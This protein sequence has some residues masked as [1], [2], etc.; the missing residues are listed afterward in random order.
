MDALRAADFQGPLESVLG[1]GQMVAGVAMLGGSVLG[2]V[3][4]QVTNLGVPFLMRV[5][6]LL[7]R[8]IVAARMMH[9][10]G[11]T[12]RRATHP[13][14]E[15]KAVLSA[16]IEHGLR[17]RPVRFVML[18]APFS[19]GVGIYVF[20]ALQ[21]FLQLLEQRPRH[22]RV[23]GERLPAGVRRQPLRAASRLASRPRSSCSSSRP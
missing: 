20:Y 8:F 4:A 16:S 9:D 5:A 11:F 23:A 17:K 14:R 6:V 1:R 12:P 19:T 15:T 18:A 13:L 3:V 21:P 2:G 10:V 22:L 7:L